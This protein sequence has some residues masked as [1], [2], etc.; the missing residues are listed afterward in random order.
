MSIWPEQRQRRIT[1]PRA[2]PEPPSKKRLS[3]DQALA[4]RNGTL[5]ECRAVFTDERVALDRVPGVVTVC[6]T[7]GGVHSASSGRVNRQVPA[8]AVALPELVQRRPVETVAKVEI[9]AADELLGDE[10][11]LA[12]D[13]DVE[14]GVHRQRRL[15]RPRQD[16]G[17][18]AVE[19]LE[20]PNDDAAN[21]ALAVALKDDAADRGDLS[22][23]I[24]VVRLKRTWGQGQRPVV[25]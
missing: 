1:D 16:A 24:G 9:Q 6:A 11:A 13:H 12:V 22:R 19:R 21:R 23:S 25:R 14:S 7:A 10:F 4:C 3:A 17:D 18:P 2:H 5:D 15:A 8:A 20:G